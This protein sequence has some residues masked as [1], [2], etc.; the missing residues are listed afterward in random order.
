VSGKYGSMLSVPSGIE[1]KPSV[2]ASA[3]WYTSPLKGE[4]RLA[5]P[6]AGEVAMRDHAFRPDQDAVAPG[7]LP[8]MRERSDASVV[9]TAM[10]LQQRAGNRSVAELVERSHA[11]PDQS[12]LAALSSAGRGPAAGTGSGAA[13]A[14]QREP[15]VDCPDAEKGPG[16]AEPEA[17]AEPEVAA[18]PG[19]MG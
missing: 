10:D 15:C 14:V 9:R 19:Q 13:V 2:A 6:C 1:T 3:R 5:R 16:P 11:D 7:R 4:L 18:G 12:P 8:V 17:A